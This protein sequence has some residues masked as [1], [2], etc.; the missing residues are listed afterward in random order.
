MIAGRD[1]QGSKLS[2][3]QFF[4][5]WLWRGFA[6][7]IIAVLVIA[8]LSLAYFS[9]EFCDVC[10]KFH[11]AFS[12]VELSVFSIAGIVLGLVP[13]Y[14][15]IWH[16][17]LSGTTNGATTRGLAAWVLGLL[18]IVPIGLVYVLLDLVSGPH[19]L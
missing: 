4:A 5:R 10:Y 15:G 14:Q 17:K 7:P 6:L 2:A 8:L 3:A 19:P 12:A 13:T 11:F 1:W 18:V 9:W 16:S